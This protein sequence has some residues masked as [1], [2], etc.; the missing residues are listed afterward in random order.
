MTREQRTLL[1]SAVPVAVQGMALPT[2]SRSSNLREHRTGRMLISQAGT[3][4]VKLTTNTSQLV[5]T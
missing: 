2:V 3:E 5:W 1:L 4:F